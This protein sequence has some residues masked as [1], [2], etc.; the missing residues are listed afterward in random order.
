MIALNLN[1]TAK[2]PFFHQTKKA[3]EF[4][5]LSETFFVY[6]NLIRKNTFIAMMK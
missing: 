1:D 3:L 2:V 4:S 5:N 6:R